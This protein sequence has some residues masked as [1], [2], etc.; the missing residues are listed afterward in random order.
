MAKLHHHIA[1]HTKRY[2]SHFTKYLY[3]RD[4]ILSLLMVFVFILLV[5]FL[6][7]NLHFLD[8]MKLALADFDFNDIAYAKLGKGESTSIE[9]RIVVV[10]IGHLDR[11]ELAYL[12]EKTG[13]MHPAV[14]GLDAY[15]DGPKDATK[16]SVLQTVFSKTKNLVVISRIKAEHHHKGGKL[17][18]QKDFFD[19]YVAN[20]GYANLVGEEGGT[21]RYYS[22]FE[23]I[24]DE[25]YP[26][27]TS[28]LIKRY[29]ETVYEK[30]EK[31]HKAVE[32]IN[33]A[34]RTEL[35]Q[36]LESEDVMMDNFIFKNR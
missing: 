10:N 24:E 26:S 34:R 27:F 16:D 4:T 20:R 12:I 25:K 9:K 21:I 17:E 3:E 29:N 15:F 23:K 18:L 36:V 6:P 13:S 14:M 11:E 7:L 31:R 32:M 2:I 19:P 1:R 8:P 5:K 33:Y 28:A 30:L 22:P 35:Y